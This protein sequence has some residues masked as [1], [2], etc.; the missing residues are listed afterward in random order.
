[1]QVLPERVLL[2]A[3]VSLLAL[4][5]L[6]ASPYSITLLNYI[7]IGALIALGL[8]ASRR[9]ARQRL[10]VS[11]PIRQRGSPRRQGSHRGSGWQRR[12]S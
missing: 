6:V 7:G 9:L 11:V 10:Q 8:A 4:A 1:M 2:I 3:C 12:S 5:P